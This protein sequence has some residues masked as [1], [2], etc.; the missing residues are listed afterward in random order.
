V[1][2]VTGS[3]IVEVVSVQ[4]G[5]IDVCRNNELYLFVSIVS[6]RILDDSTHYSH[7]LCSRRS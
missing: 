5:N 4:V 6:F 3:D 1:A 2:A 7:H